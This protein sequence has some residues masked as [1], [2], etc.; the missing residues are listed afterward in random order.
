MKKTISTIL[1]MALLASS[2]SMSAFAEAESSEINQTNVNPNDVVVTLTEEKMDGEINYITYTW[3][4]LSCTVYDSNNNVVYSGPAISKD[5]MT[6]GYSIAGGTVKSEGTS[7]WFPTDNENGF[8]CGNGIAVTVSIKTNATA[9]K[10]IG[11]TN[12]E[13]SKSTTKNPS[14]ILYTGTSGYWKF[15]VSNHS[16][17]AFNVTGGSLSWGE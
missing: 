2:L 4:D 3:E 12:G 8:K 11:L 9:S 13:S 16:S 15:Y 14:A 5:P 10:T 17:S 1:S 6:R 7:Y